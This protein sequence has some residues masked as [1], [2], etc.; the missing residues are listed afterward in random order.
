MSL[1]ILL[2]LVTITLNEACK[3]SIEVCTCDTN[4][5]SIK[6]IQM[7]CLA[8]SNETKN[9]DF[10]EVNLINVNN[11]TFQLTLQNKIF[12]SIK[13]ANTSLARQLVSL[14]ITNSKI[15]QINADSFVDFINLR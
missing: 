14:I 2:F 7:N 1:T 3:L 12:S 6:F 4:Q 9:L 15:E 13:S 10:N 11:L 5:P 8:I